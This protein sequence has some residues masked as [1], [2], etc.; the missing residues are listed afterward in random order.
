M[1]DIL[2]F[3][4]NRSTFRDARAWLRYGHRCAAGGDH[5]EAVAAFEI[6]LFIDPGLSE[7]R[8][9]LAALRRRP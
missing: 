6:A 1:A 9:A 5:A 3:P 7:A 4:A 8:G 2:P